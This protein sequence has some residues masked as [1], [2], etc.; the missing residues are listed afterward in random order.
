MPEGWSKSRDLAKLA[1]M[2]AHFDLGIPLG[3]LPGIPAEFSIADGPV[4]AWLQFGREQ[5]LP[6]VQIR[7]EAAL[8][9]VCQRCLGEMRLDVRTESRLAVVDSEA[10][11]AR[12]P[13]EFETFL[14][15]EGHSSLAALVAEELMLALPIVPRHTAGER[16]LGAGAAEAEPPPADAAAE[17]TQRPFAQLRSLLERDRN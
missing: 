10:Q 15:A 11:A 9:P 1:E 17:E 4:R 2:R 14:A 8:R 6:M 12:V 16:C 3:E 5:G 7:L 13:E